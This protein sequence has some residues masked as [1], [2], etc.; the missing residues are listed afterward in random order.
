[1]SKLLF[2]DSNNTGLLSTPD[3]DKYFNED[4]DYIEYIREKCGY[5]VSEYIRNI[6]N[7]AELKAC[8]PAEIDIDELAYSVDNFISALDE[9]ET[10]NCNNPI[11]KIKKL[12]EFIPVLNKVFIILT[13]ISELG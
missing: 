7:M 12:E 6:F 13:N 11:L 10:F 9:I 3:G 2:K 1:M 8:I 4:R 5:E